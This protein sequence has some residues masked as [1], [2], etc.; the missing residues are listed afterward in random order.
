MLAYQQNLTGDCLHSWIRTYV[1]TPSFLTVPA[2][3]KHWT[4]VIPQG[5]DRLSTQTMRCSFC[6]LCERGEASLFRGSAPSCWHCALVA[7]SSG[8]SL[9]I[10]GSAWMRVGFVM[11]QLSVLRGRRQGERADKVEL[12]VR[13]VYADA[14]GPVGCG[15]TA[16]FPYVRVLL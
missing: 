12:T 11:K 6:S 16:S 4:W 10:T 3:F 7:C 5:K 2:W 13:P 8:Q 1:C 15:I 14:Q 9:I